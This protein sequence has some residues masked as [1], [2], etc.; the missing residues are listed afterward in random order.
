MGTRNVERPSTDNSLDSAETE[1]EYFLGR[2]RPLDL[3]GIV[4]WQVPQYPLTVETIRTLRYMEHIES[5]T[6]VFPRTIFSTRAI[7][8]SVVVRFLTC[9]LYEESFHGPALA[10]FLKAAGHTAPSPYPKRLS[11]KDRVEAAV[12]TLVSS[13]WSDFLALHMTWGAIH[14]LTTITAYQRLAALA[15]H[16]ILTDLVKRIVREEAR[17]FA[18][19]YSQARKRLAR[20]VVASITRFLLNQLWAPVGHGVQSIAAEQS[21]TGYLF[22]DADGRTA[23]RKVDS[24]IRRLPGLA[25]VSLLESWIARKVGCWSAA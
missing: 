7:T 2:S 25:R 9:W 4:W 23:A 5:H 1:I 19:Y 17:H 6:A 20:P 16:P 15:D 22:A 10:R 12:S 11:A 18:F 14:E 13:A 21:V 3:S 24:T 8:D